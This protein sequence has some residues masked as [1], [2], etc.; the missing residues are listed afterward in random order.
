MVGGENITTDFKP[1]KNIVAQSLIFT[2]FL[3]HNTFHFS[4]IT[5]KIGGVNQTELGRGIK[6]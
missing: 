1:S 6:Y 3:Y 4:N 5:A 2:Y